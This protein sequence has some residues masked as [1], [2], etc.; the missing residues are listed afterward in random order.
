MAMNGVTMVYNLLS[1]LITGIIFSTIYIVPI[2]ILFKNTFSTNVE[3]F[4]EY[5]DAFIFW[6]LFTAHITHLISFGMHIA[7]YFS[8]RK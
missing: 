1:W 4:L 7:A 3:A 6:L 2:I 8:K 5:G